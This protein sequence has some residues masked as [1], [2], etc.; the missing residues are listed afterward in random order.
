MILLAKKEAICPPS[1]T[2][3][4]SLIDS[5]FKIGERLFLTRFRDILV[6]RGLLPDN[7]SGLRD[8]FRL[9]TR[10]L[11]FLEDLYS[12]K[13]FQKHFAELDVKVLLLCSVVLFLSYRFFC[14]PR[15]NR[16]ARKRPF[17][18]RNGDIRRSYTRSVYDL[19]IRSYTM[20]TGIRIRRS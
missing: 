1:L 3:P 7:Q 18:G 14:F 4:I 12:C 17:T 19:R 6:C 10:L 20:R 11:L 15:S 8:G 16:Q 5:F 9:Q 2:R 13:S